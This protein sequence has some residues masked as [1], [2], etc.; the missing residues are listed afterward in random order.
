MM[1]SSM[2]AI[3]HFLSKRVKRLKNNKIIKLVFQL[4]FST[5]LP[6]FLLKFR[7]GVLV[8]WKINSSSKEYPCCILLMDPTT[9]KMR[10]T[11]KTWFQSCFFM[12]FSFFC[13]A[14]SIKSMKHGH[15]LDAQL[16]FA[17][18]EYSRLKFEQK[19]WEISWKYELK[20]LFYYF[21]IF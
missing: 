13:L 10:N 3:Q 21:I 14:G 1:M 18:N 6:N 2:G 9:W 5:Y 11:W 16:N 20:K 4:I 19:I 12:Y 7:V 17:S 8:G 15:S